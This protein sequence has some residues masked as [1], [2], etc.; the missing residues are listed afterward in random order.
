MASPVALAMFN[1]LEEDQMLGRFLV[2]FIV[3]ED[4]ERAL[5]NIALICQGITLGSRY[6][7]GVRLDG[8]IFSAEVNSAFI[9]TID[10]QP[11]KIVYVIRDISKRKHVEEER[12]RLQEKLEQ[13]QK[14]ES[15][16]RL[17]GGVAHD[18]NNMLGVILGYT[19]LGMLQTTEDNPLNGYF[20]KIQEAAQRSAALT[21]QLLAF[22][23]C[24]TI[25]PKV[26]D[27]NVSVTETLDMLQ[28]LLGENIEVKWLPPAGE[29]YPVLIDPN[30]FG[31][32][33]VNLCVNARDAI[34]GVGRITIETENMTLDTDYCAA[35]GPL[36][37]GDYVLLTVSDNGCGMNKEVQSKIF[38]PFFTTK[39][40]GQGTGLGL[41][42]VYGIIKQNSGFI[43]VY[44]EPG[45][46]T[47]FK[48]YLPRY[49]D[50][51]IEDGGEQFASVFKNF[52]E[53]IL[54]VED[55]AL[56]L[57]INTTMLVGLG[58]KVL[59]AG[60]PT[61]AL[62]LA[63]EHAGTIDL[64]MTDVIMPEMNGRQLQQR[65]QDSNPRMRCLFMSGYTANVISHHGVLDKNVHFIQKPFN[66]REMA[67]KLREVL[68]EEP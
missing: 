52:G 16:G 13:A 49:S 51:A 45:Q 28:S 43:N 30:Q 58:Y 4:R 36:V 32:L 60:T 15:V 23:R 50:S 34:I 1:C 31:Q 55:E 44:S 18:Y 33:L 11:T 63:E 3:P 48:I 8:S 29:M 67:M 22:A 38:E 7:Q 61:E 39:G 6:Y 53:T 19:D 35:N 41:A 56:L 37:P 47:A 24:Q 27:V 2:D 68:E 14:L 20:T 40:V 46:G 5:A 54:V 57:G 62:R 42:T 26:I 65:M 66:R 25:T 9:R 17:A 59:A 12:A 21:Q 64:L 10:R